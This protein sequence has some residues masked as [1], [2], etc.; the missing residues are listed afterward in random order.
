MASTF[1]IQ[2]GLTRETGTSQTNRIQTSHPGRV[3]IRDQKRQHVLHDL[4]LCAHYRVA[5]QAHK[6]MDADFIGKINVILH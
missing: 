4:R 2:P 3:A 6:L 5:S 1:Q